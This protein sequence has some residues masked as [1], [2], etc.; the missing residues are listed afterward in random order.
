MYE[1]QIGLERDEL[2]QYP[3]EEASELAMIYVA[4]G[5]PEGEAQKMAN[6]IL[7]DPTR[8]LDTLARE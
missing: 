1:Y 5:I 6:V 3:E 8:A 7:V 2:E 4:R